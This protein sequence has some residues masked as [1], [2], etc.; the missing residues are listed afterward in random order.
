MLRNKL[1]TFHLRK[2]GSRKNNE[3]AVTEYFE[4][5][6][7]DKAII[8]PASGRMQ[9]ELYGL[10]LTNILNVNYYG[11]L[12]IAE[13]DCLCIDVGANEEPDYKVISVKK[14]PKFML[15]EAEKRIV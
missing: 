8:W 4:P 12:N 13:N 1:K 15:I 10:R 9:A 14:Y 2:S 3:G 6:V 5:A 7:E 11:A